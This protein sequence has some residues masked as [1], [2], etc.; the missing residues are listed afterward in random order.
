MPTPTALPASFSPG[1]VLTAAN[2]NL[3]R[4][5]FRIL[6]VVFAETDTIISNSTTVAADTG[7]SAT[8]TPQFASSKV[9]VFVSQ[10]CAKDGANASNALVLRLLRGATDIGK[11][12]GA[13]LYTGT[14]MINIGCISTCELDS[15]NTTSAVT[16]KTTFANYTASASV[17]VQT[18]TAQSTMILMEVSA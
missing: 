5:G 15:P 10:T 9:L 4:G 7:L 13:G 14:T 12:A 2:M 16:Y 17:S 18:N 3:I 11:F 1:D 6:Q 8:I